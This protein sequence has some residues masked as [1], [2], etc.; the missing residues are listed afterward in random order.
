MPGPSRYNRKLKAK[1]DRKAAR[2]S[3]GGLRSKQG[4]TLSSS[5]PKLGSSGSGSTKARVT[6]RP[7]TRTF[8][9]GRGSRKARRTNNLAQPP[10]LPGFL[11]DAQEAAQSFLNDRERDVREGARSFLAELDKEEAQKRRTLQDPNASVAERLFAFATSGGNPVGPGMLKGPA[12]G[13]LRAALST[14]RTARSLRAASTPVKSTRNAASKARQGGQKATQAVGRKARRIKNQAKTPKGRK[15]LAKDTAKG[16]GRAA[17]ATGKGAVKRAGKSKVAPAAA[18]VVFADEQG[19]AGDNKTVKGAANVIQGRI[20]ALNPMNPEGNFDP[21]PFGPDSQD[22]PLGRSIYTTGRFIPGAIAGVAK[23]VG[24]GAE[25]GSR[26]AR[27]W[28]EELGGLTG[29]PVAKAIGKDYTA[30]EV[31]AP[32][33]ETAKET[34]R[35]LDQMTKPI[36]EGDREGTQRAFE[37]QIGIPGA[38][39]G[40]RGAKMARE[41]KTY[42]NVRGLARD[43]A[44]YRRAK[45]G[46]KAEENRR[47]QNEAD[48]VVGSPP[49]PRPERD[50]RSRREDEYVFQPLGR[51]IENRRADRAVSRLGDRETRAAQREANYIA[52]DLA[53]LL[54]RGRKIGGRKKAKKFAAQL[55]GAVQVVAQQAIGRDPV[56]A[57]YELE[58]LLKQIGR[59]DANDPDITGRLGDRQ[60]VRFL[61]DNP[62]V[63][64]SDVFW[65]AVDRVKEVTREG[66]VA[67]KGEDGGMRA[68]YEAP[69]NRMG[70]KTPERVVEEDGVVVGGRLVRGKWT[71]E[72]DRQW[73]AKADTLRAEA[74]QLNTEIRALDPSSPEWRKKLEQAAEKL[75][76][77]AELMAKRNGLRKAYKIA[78]KDFV[79]KTRSASLLRG[80]DP[81]PAYIRD[82]TR[83]QPG[84]DSA[85]IVEKA[86]LPVSKPI[87]NEQLREGSLRLSG[88]ADRSFDTLLRET[89]LRPRVI[90]AVNRLTR[91]VIGRYHFKVKDGSGNLAMVNT[92]EDIAKAVG[93]GEVPSGY[94]AVHSQFYNGAFRGRDTQMDEMDIDRIQNDGA[95]LITTPQ[96]LADDIREG[97]TKPG[98]KYILVR[99]SAWDEYLN[100]LQGTNNRFIKGVTRL[101]RLAS[102]G[103]LGYNPSWAVAQQ[104][105]E[106]IPA[107]LA[108]GISPGAWNYIIQA[109]RAYKQLSPE[110]RAIIDSVSGSAGGTLR[111]FGNIK[112]GN[113]PDYDL[114]RMPRRV[115]EN[116]IYQKMTPRKPNEQDYQD[117]AAG[118]NERG[119]ATLKDIAKGRGL[120][121]LVLYT[122][123]IYRR[124]VMNAAIY[125]QRRDAILGLS[126]AASTMREIDKRVG[127]KDVA[128][129]LAKNPREA[130][131][132]A[133]YMEDV[134]GNWTSL[135]RREGNIAPFIAFYP[136]LRYSLRWTFYGFPVR[137][138]IKAEMLYFLAQQNANELEEFLGGKPSNWIDYAFPVITTDPGKK[139]RL[140]GATRFQPALSAVVEAIGTD[141]MERLLGAVNPI[142][143]VGVESIL[144]FDSYKG[145][146]VAYGGLDRA[147]LAVSGFFSMIAPVRWADGLVPEGD[148][149]DLLG[150]LPGVPTRWPGG[151]VSAITPQKDY[152]KPSKSDVPVL[153]RVPTRSAASKA[154][155]RADPNAYVENLLDLLTS[156]SS[157]N[158]LAP[159]SQ[160]DARR[161]TRMEKAFKEGDFS[162][163]GVIG[164]SSSSSYDPLGIYGGSKKSSSSTTY[165]PLGLYK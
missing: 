44:A 41:S 29:D 105:A 118:M 71:P 7:S 77:A 85:A 58:K 88:K 38:A 100:Q 55:A 113:L 5:T 15:Q 96:K 156:R 119:W 27:T 98:H 30:S 145:E 126:R 76:E 149:P 112:T 135:T 50:S 2:S 24:A 136:Y 40:P 8:S 70:I 121:E 147:L 153:D 148:I 164:G 91:E 93:R 28:I 150:N 52:G 151:T 155:R 75:D 141:K 95:E 20:D 79:N 86:G 17:K 97:Q 128:T 132:I 80:Q 33:R 142:L 10:D 31:I 144:G 64:E 74:R 25:T 102:T 51:F 67:L 103:L 157:L 158:V 162:L 101:N 6:A 21:L 62:D 123:G 13:T 49:Q 104:L 26:A 3:S 82:T 84:A 130:E 146:T 61:L 35:G 66:T 94:V 9:T 22:S 160:A 1:N 63:L 65:T 138:P 54:S 4:Q 99:K 125:R 43:S 78:E 37:T 122:G 165:D 90:R 34:L 36:R 134:M 19:L 47:R 56:R 18:A 140:K 116:P 57:R 127:P 59:P 109:E 32:V 163:G 161:E 46:K 131:K 14:T 45:K 72:L 92:T 60:V 152:S 114:V 159:Q 83:P 81:T 12:S 23:G 16:A 110:Q 42:Q 68:L 73:V 53:K 124:G 39:L 48:E 117:F 107:L 106:G 111:S 133:S 129:Y 115:K 89:I 137:H 87:V 154:F 143:S 139:T 11:G 69:A 108:I 120:N